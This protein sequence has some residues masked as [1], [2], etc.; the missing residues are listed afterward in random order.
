M[1]APLFALFR[2]FVMPFVAIY[3]F[4]RAFSRRLI[5]QGPTTTFQWFRTVGLAWLTGRLALGFSAVTEQVY[6][7]PQYGR[8]GLETL[9]QI[10]VTASVNMRAEFDDEKYGLT[11]EDYCYLPVIDNT[12]PTLEQLA[13]GVRFMQEAIANDGIVYVHCGSGVG[14]SPAMVAA[15]LISTGMTLDAAVEQI[16][17]ARPFVRILPGQMERLREFEAQEHQQPVGE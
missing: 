9:E 1:F 12:P 17:S 2:I 15:Y 8:F 6:L 11:F 7:G 14:R 4:L 3:Q 5:S 16:E 13:D 10:G